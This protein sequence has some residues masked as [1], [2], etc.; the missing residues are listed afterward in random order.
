MKYYFIICLIFILKSVYSQDFEHINSKNG[1]PS[2]NIFQIEKDFKGYLW[3]STNLGLIRYDGYLFENYGVN[4]K[5]DAMAIEPN[6]K[7][8]FSNNNGLFFIDQN[9]QKPVKKISSNL[10]DSLADNDHYE[11]LYIDK[12]GWI[13]STDFHHIKVYKPNEKTILAFKIL[14]NNTQNPKIARFSSGPNGQLWSISHLGLCKFNY[15]TNKWVSYVAKSNLSCIFYDSLAKRWLLGDKKGNIYSYDSNSKKITF[16]IRLKGEILDIEKKQ[17]SFFVL[18]S[19]GLCKLSTNFSKIEKLNKNIDS[20]VEYRRIFVFNNSKIFLATDDGIY[21]EIIDNQTISSHYF[22][23]ELNI[24]KS[25]TLAIAKLNYHSLLMGLDNGRLIIWNKNLNSFEM[26]KA[27]NIGNINQIVVHKNIAYI[28]SD[29]GLYSLD[30][31]KRLK[32]LLPGTF[33]SL[34]VDNQDRVWLISSNK[35]IVVFEVRLQKTTIPWKKLP[36]PKF[37]EENLLKK[38]IYHNNKMWVAGWLPKGF[39]MLF[40]D[41][42]KNE[43]VQLSDLNPDAR[44]VSDYYLDVAKSNKGNIYFSAYGGFNQVNE[45]GIITEVY[46][47]DEHIQ[48]VPDNQYFKIATDQYQNTWIGTHEGLVKIKPNGSIKR[49]TQFD[50]LNSNIIT[51]GFYLD[52]NEL[53]IGSKNGFN[54]VNL[55]S[56]IVIKKSNL[57]I[58]HVKIMGSKI[59]NQDLSKLVFDK[60]DNNISIAFSPLSFEQKNTYQFHYRLKNTNNNWINVGTNPEI[61]LV[62]LEKGKYQLEL[63]ILDQINMQN[64]QNTLLNFEIL[65]AWY[66]TLWFRVL[67]SALIFALI[68]AFYKFRLNQIRKVYALRNRISADLHDE[69]GASLSSIGILGGLLKQNLTQDPKNNGFA[70]MIAEEAKKAGNAIDYIIWNINP[71]YDSLESLFTKINKEASELIETQNIQYEFESNDLSGKNMSLKN[72]RN[73]YLMLKELINN[74]IKHSQSTKISLKCSLSGNFL[75][76]IFEDNGRGFDVT[77]QSNRNGLKNLKARVK[78]MQGQIQISSEIGKGTSVQFKLPLK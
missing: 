41:L 71:K 42:N 4:S 8:W 1:L 11:S 34:S 78:Q 5:I 32:F 68:Y 56:Q 69:I 23:I 57:Y 60:K 22:P 46:K 62:N 9:L 44:F 36:Y 54:V 15:Q 51:N 45:Q 53:Y 37:F 31:Q 20:D 16:I 25:K 13:W 38:I 3:I 18:I 10:A 2:N 14:A 28:S 19:D 21:E 70:E 61:N 50:G 35:P 40:Y 75:F 59:R 58:S 65:P 26:V 7:V 72:K 48:Q 77:Q 27:P 66:E 47:S 76:L 49:F 73:L 29:K 55:S 63:A 33:K 12:K 39:G 74:A 52:S 17:N 43:F 30:K 6:G 64:S 24:N 67:L